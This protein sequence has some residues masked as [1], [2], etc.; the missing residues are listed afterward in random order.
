MHDVII[1][2]LSE[3]LPSET[4]SHYK[5]GKVTSFRIVLIT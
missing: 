4:F 2:E 1:T 5:H 3:I